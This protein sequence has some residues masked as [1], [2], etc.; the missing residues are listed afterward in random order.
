M[1]QGKSEIGEISL[2]LKQEGNEIILSFADDGA[3]LDFERIRA[4]GI[5]AGLLQANEDVDAER[6]GESDFHAR[7]FDRPEVSQVAGRG[8]GMDVVKPRSAALAAGSKRYPR[9]GGERNS[10]STF[11]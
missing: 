3:G 6:P 8:I 9:G 1:Q 4:R 2:A 11:R 7:F 5:E 10:A